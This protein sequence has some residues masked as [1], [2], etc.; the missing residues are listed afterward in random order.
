VN[1][2]PALTFSSDQLFPPGATLTRD[3]AGD[4]L[5]CCPEG[6][7]TMSRFLNMNQHDE[8]EQFATTV[9]RLREPMKRAYLAAVEASNLCNEM[10]HESMYRSAMAQEFNVLDMFVERPRSA[11]PAKDMQTAR[12]L[13]VGA[14]VEDMQADWQATVVVL[15]ADDTLRRLKRRVLPQ[16]RQREG[17][18]TTYRDGVRLTELLWAGANAIR[19]VSEWDDDDKLVFPYDPTKIE[20]GSNQERAWQNILVFQRAFG[21]GIH[22]RIREMQSWAIL[23]TMDGLY[24]THHPD[25]AR[26]EEAIV[27]A[28]REIAEAAGGDALQRL[29]AA[30][31]ANGI[32]IEPSTPVLLE[33]WKHAALAASGA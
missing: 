32:A 19:H 1:G 9:R 16:S 24:G 6:G 31:A 21:K 17:F 22:E 27:K 15:F 7:Y 2:L 14:E 30:L 33:R 20:K 13:H 25:Y 5:G 8:Y 3:P 12:E 11:Y 10:L 28:A 26:V 29:D 18:G 4:M 23:C